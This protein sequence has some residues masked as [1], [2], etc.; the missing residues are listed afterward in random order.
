VIISAIAVLVL[1]GAGLTVYLLTRSDDK[2]AASQGDPRS[3]GPGATAPATAGQSA[4]TPAAAPPPP[5][6]PAAA[7]VG[8][9][10]QVAEQA[11]QA[12]N[13]HN[14]DALKKISCDPRAVDPADNAAPEARV[15]LAANPELTGDT[16]TVELKLIIG[17]QSTTTPLPLRKQNG[18]WC[19]D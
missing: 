11:V 6:G 3:G 16:A 17:D 18:V 5:T 9:A 10:R 2:P 7:E 8:S 4:S 14:A 1:A 15:E 19:V 13:A 12:F